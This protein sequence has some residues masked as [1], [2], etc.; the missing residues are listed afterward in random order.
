MEN[1]SKKYPKPIDGYT[2]RSQEGSQLNFAQDRTY[3]VIIVH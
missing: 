2:I 1:K 3:K